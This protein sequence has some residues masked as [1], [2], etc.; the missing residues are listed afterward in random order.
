[1]ISLIPEDSQNRLIKRFGAKF[2]NFSKLEVQALVTAD[3]EEWVDNARMRQITSLHATDMTKLLQNLVSKSA[4]IQ[5]GQGRWTR[6]SLPPLPDSIHMRSDYLYLGIDSLHMRSDSLHS[7]EVTDNELDDLY[8]TAEP[9]RQ[10]RRLSSK[11][12]ESIVLKLC[13]RHWITRRRLAELLDRNEEGIRSRFLAP[14]V[15]HG[16]LRLRYP[17]KPNR[18]DQAYTLS[19]KEK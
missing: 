12:L 1:M 10:S 18:V 9:A 11:Q 13:E 15:Q 4:L 7:S 3:L 6:Y 14:M 8:K 16:L 19:E 2:Q 17:D 5:D